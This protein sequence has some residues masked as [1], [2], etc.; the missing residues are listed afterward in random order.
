ML[1]VENIFE[2]AQTV[3]RIREDRSNEFIVKLCNEGM[4]DHFDLLQIYDKWVHKHYSRGD[5]FTP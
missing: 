5:I 4:G 3:R 2:D 1:S